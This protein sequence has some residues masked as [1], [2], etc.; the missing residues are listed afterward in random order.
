MLKAAV[1]HGVFELF[2]VPGRIEAAV[3]FKGFEGLGLFS[4]LPEGSVSDELGWLY[5]SDGVHAVEFVLEP[6]TY[7]RG[8][9]P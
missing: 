5:M 9:I 4:V 6:S 8:T 2:Y 7:C 1:A 3:G